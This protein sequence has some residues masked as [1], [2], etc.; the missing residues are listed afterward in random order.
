MP[1]YHIT[2][3]VDITRSNPSRQDTDQV[4]IAQQSNFNS[5]VQGIGIRSN[6]SWDLDPKRIVDKNNAVW[7]WTFEVERE[8]VFTKADDPVGLLKDDLQGI[9]VIKNLT[10]TDPLN[11]PIF[12]TLGD[13]PNTLIKSI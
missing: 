11:K 4:M 13:K 6:V 3:T 8:D 2:T 9:P 7:E 12:I 1:R 5:L 10:N